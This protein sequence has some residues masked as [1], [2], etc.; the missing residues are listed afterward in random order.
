MNA[1]TANFAGRVP[2]KP[3]MQPEDFMLHPYKKLDEPNTLTG[4]YVIA[5]LKSSGVKVKHV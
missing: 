2:P 1:T 3:P 5:L 4:E